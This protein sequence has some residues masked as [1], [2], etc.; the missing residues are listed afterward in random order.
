MPPVAA[1]SPLAR[2][3]RTAWWCRF[4]AA[5]PPRPA[6]QRCGA[7]ELGAAVEP[8]LTAD[9]FGAVQLVDPRLGVEQ[10]LD[11]QLLVQEIEPCRAADLPA[12]ISVTHEHIARP[13]RDLVRRD[14]SVAI[15]VAERV[16][17][18]PPPVDGVALHLAGGGPD[19]RWD[20]AHVRDEVGVFAEVE[21]HVPAERRALDHPGVDQPLESP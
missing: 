21:R 16:G 11:A 17:A 2:C 18:L 9:P 14:H 12:G 4:R 10:T 13:D 7:V 3:T 19:D 5:L 15:E 6:A 8:G 1:G 20:A